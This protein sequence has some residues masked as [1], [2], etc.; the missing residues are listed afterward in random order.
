VCGW[1]SGRTPLGKPAEKLHNIGEASAGLI[2]EGGRDAIF[3][4]LLA[5][6]K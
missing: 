2:M 6:L 3:M 4:A 1:K 5:H